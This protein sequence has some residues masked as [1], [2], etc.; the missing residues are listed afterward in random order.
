M[1][2]QRDRKKRGTERGE[3]QKEERDRKR[4]RKSRGGTKEQRG[5]EGAEEEKR[6]R[7]SRGTERAEG[8]EGAARAQ[9]RAIKEPQAREGTHRAHKRT[10]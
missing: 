9:Q 2:E 7:K 4:D 6:D 5:N 3:G 10:P 1:K 8:T